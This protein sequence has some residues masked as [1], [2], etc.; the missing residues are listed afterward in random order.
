MEP[1]EHRTLERCLRDALDAHQF[2]LHYQPQIEQR[3][4]RI[5]G[6]EALLR[7][8]HPECGLL[9]ANH[10]LQTLE[11]TGL[12]VPVGDWAIRRA[13]ED[14]ERWQRLGLPRLKIGVNVSLTQLARRVHD[15]RVF[16]I[17]PL[18]ALCDLEIEIDS[19]EIASASDD[20]MRVL[21]LLRRDGTDVAAQNF[22]I[23]DKVFERLWLL[24]VDVL[25]IDRSIV[26]RLT[27]D[28]HADDDVSGL[29][30]V[31]RAFRMVSVAE[32]VETSA[33]LERLAAYGCQR[34]QGFLRSPALPAAELEELLRAETGSSRA[35]RSPRRPQFRHS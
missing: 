4:G 32:G 9:G 2:R 24:P 15:K 26:Q 31:A 25:K 19:R 5:V 17:S 8:Q 34:W 6:A 10:F 23:D 11:S 1:V 27:M 35:R 29:L 3:T 20:I 22:G 28:E 33:Q 14:C 7:W 18:Q 16:D 21:T 12:I 13:A 30:A